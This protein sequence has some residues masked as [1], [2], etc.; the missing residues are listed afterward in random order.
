M[1][2]ERIPLSHYSRADLAEQGSSQRISAIPA[3]LADFRSELTSA[4]VGSFAH[5]ISAIPGG[6]SHY[7]PNNQ[8]AGRR[9]ATVCP[10]SC[11]WACSVVACCLASFDSAWGAGLS[12]GELT[13]A[14]CGSDGMGSLLGSQLSVGMPAR[15]YNL[16]EYTAM[17]RLKR[18][19]ESMC[20]RVFKSAAQVC[21]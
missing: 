18:C 17:Q 8:L 12:G 19:V 14:W 9:Y 3:G 2:V 5:R 16:A 7:L 21:F 15:R 6:T 20:M 1:V 10:L 11:E 13:F 4:D